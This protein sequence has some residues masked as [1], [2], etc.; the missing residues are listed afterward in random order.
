ME[1]WI[2]LT[3][4]PTATACMA[5]ESGM[6]SREQPTGTRS[7]DPPATPE[8]PQIDQDTGLTP[9]VFRFLFPEDD[10]DL[11]VLAQQAVDSFCL[12]LSCF[13]NVSF[14]LGD[15][16]Q[17]LHTVTVSFIQ[18]FEKLFCTGHPFQTIVEMIHFLDLNPHGV[19]TARNPCRPLRRRLH[20]AQ[21]PY[22]SL[23]IRQYTIHIKINLLNHDLPPVSYLLPYAVTPEMAHSS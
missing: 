13:G 6:P 9:A 12:I 16:G 10:I 7:S 21:F 17:D 23:K 3:I 19:I 15:A 4:N 5:R 1:S 8:A 22:S 14:W 18:L 2:T 20:A 11:D